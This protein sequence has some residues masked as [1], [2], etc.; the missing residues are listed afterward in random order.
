MSPSQMESKAR[1]DPKD[2]AVALHAGCWDRPAG[3]ILG[4]RDAWNSGQ[5]H[6]APTAR[7]T[8]REASSLQSL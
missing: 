7:A 8:L 6:L 3:R 4:D 2:R 1:R 5:V